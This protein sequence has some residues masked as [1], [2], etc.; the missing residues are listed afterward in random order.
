[1]TGKLEVMP[2]MDSQ[3]RWPEVGFGDMCRK[4][5]KHKR[6]PLKRSPRFLIGNLQS[7]AEIAQTF[8]YSLSHD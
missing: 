1:M 2:R 6:K 5:V 8:W 7:L 4:Q 3:R